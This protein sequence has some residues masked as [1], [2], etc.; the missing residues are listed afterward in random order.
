VRCRLAREDDRAALLEM[1][2]AMVAELRPMLR[3]DER[4][5]RRHFDRHFADPSITFFVVE[6]G[7]AVAGFLCAGRCDYAACS[8]FYVEQQLF[9]VRP[10]MRGSRA[11]ATL[12][13]G[14]ARWAED[15]RPEEI[16][17]GIGWGRRSA[18]AAR[19]LRNFGFEPAGQQIMRRR[20]GAH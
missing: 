18:A 13:A 9:Y 12:F 7:G 17:A 2:R 19:W 10:E 14:F 4:R 3:F 8:G 11:A 15:Q 5:A 1:G 16:F 20:V 6:E